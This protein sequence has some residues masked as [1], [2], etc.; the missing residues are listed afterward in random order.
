[1]LE[2]RFAGWTIFDPAVFL[3]VSEIP[4]GHYAQEQALACLGDCASVIPL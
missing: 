2:P 3:T 4:L 1:M